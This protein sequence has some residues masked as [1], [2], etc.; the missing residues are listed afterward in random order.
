MRYQ[1]LQI[2]ENKV[3]KMFLKNPHRSISATFRTLKTKRYTSSFGDYPI[4]A[5]I[6]NSIIN[7]GIMPSRVQV[8]HALNQSSELVECSKRTK[9]ELLDALLSYA[10]VQTKMG[11][12]SAGQA[13]NI[14]MSNILTDKKSN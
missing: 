9:I 10:N 5:T 4:L 1:N 2:T 8:R 13:I 6:V 7:L 11:K 3:I 14:K 12:N